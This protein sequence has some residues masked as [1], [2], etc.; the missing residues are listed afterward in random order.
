MRTKKALKNTLTSFILEI[1]TILCGFILPKLLLKKYGSEVN[2]LIASITTLVGYISLLQAGFGPVIKAELYKPIVEKDKEKIKKILKTAENFFRGISY[3]LIGYVILLCIFYPIVVNTSF[4]SSFIVLMIVIISIST[5]AEYFFGITYMT[6]LQ[7]EQK[8]YVISIIQII[9][10]LM[11]LVILYFLIKMDFNILWV[12]LVSSLIFILKPIIQNIYVKKYFNISLK[13]VEGKMEIKN[14]W[15]GLSQH[16]A[17]TLSTGVD[18]TVLTV[19]RGVREVSVY[20]VYHLVTSGIRGLIG[21]FYT[22]IDAMFGN[23]IAKKEQEGLNKKFSIYENVYFLITSIMCASTMVLILPFIKVYTRNIT[24]INYIRYGFAIF[25]VI[26][27]IMYTIRKPYTSLVYAAGKFKETQIW[28]WVEVIANLL[29]SILLAKKYGL[30]GVTIGTIIS[31]AIRTF[32]LIY[33]SSK[34]ILKRSINRTLRVILLNFIIIFIIY[35][36]GY[37]IEKF[38]IINSYLNWLIYAIVVLIIATII[39]LFINIIFYKDNIM[40]A[41]NIIINSLKNRRKII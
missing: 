10:K 14:R 6:Y 16:V 21:S 38:F 17:W 18:S 20:S 15:A 41:K 24:D 9:L 13:N 4:D 8:N 11:N 26:A 39:S 22:G 37:N 30:I 32:E 28:A 7:S 2:G 25:I 5:F 31:L 27:E 40:S 1:V 35:M 3:I 19:L 29:L 34:Y 36:V 23:M 33:Y 12:K